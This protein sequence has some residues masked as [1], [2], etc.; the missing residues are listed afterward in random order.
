[1]VLFLITRNENVFGRSISDH[2][3]YATFDIQ[4]FLVT[5]SA[6]M[7]VCTFLIPLYFLKHH[8]DSQLTN[9]P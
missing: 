7:L 5:Y 8:Y 3:A 6:L 9:I 4:V 2:E 1:M